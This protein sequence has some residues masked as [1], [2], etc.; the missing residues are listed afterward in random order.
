MNI[1]FRYIFNIFDIFLYIFLF[2][3]I[4][5]IYICSFLHALSVFFSVLIGVR[6]S[7]KNEEI[8]KKMKQ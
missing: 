5:N 6:N 7:E 1:L 2:C 8:E 3:Y 4:F